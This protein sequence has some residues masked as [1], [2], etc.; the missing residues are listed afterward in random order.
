MCVCVRH[1]RG[2]QGIEC[3]EAAWP[4]PKIYICQLGKVCILRT[5]CMYPV[6]VVYNICIHRLTIARGGDVKCP[7][8]SELS[9]GRGK[10]FFRDR[11]TARTWTQSSGFLV[12]TGHRSSKPMSLNTLRIACHLTKKA[13]EPEEKRN[14]RDVL[15]TLESS[16]LKQEHQVQ[17][18]C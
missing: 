3:K 2:S 8:A 12:A 1:P 16:G 6:Y 15:C 14:R 4:N 10:G 18:L 17:S 13:T 11:R 5:Y 7:T 9:L